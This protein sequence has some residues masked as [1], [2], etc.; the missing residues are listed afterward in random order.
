MGTA[1]DSRTHLHVSTL[2]RIQMGNAVVLYN[3]R[4]RTTVSVEAFSARCEGT[5]Q[6]CRVF[7]YVMEHLTSQRLFNSF[8]N[9]NSLLPD[10]VLAVQRQL[11]S[12]NYLRVTETKR[13]GVKGPHCPD[14]ETCP[15]RLAVSTWASKTS[16]CLL[17]NMS[18]LL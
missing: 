15:M 16:I 10:V 4:V 1:S 9:R 5:H 3:F 11:V 13:T 12:A 18:A 6:S 17:A 7:C 8:A 14:C 2:V